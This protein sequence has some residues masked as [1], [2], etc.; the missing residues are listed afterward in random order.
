MSEFA[1]ACQDLGFIC[2]WRTEAESKERV[3]AVLVDH[4]NQA[5]GTGAKSPALS[6][7]I[8]KYVAEVPAGTTTHA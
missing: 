2:D 4:L 3:V 5:H 6:G 8:D 7:L 1:G